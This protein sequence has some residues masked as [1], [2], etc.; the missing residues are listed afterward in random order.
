MPRKK[1]AAPA[2]PVAEDNPNRAATVLRLDPAL[3]G[4]LDAWVKRLNEGN[5]GPQWT[6][7]DLI[8]AALTRAVRERAEKGE[9]P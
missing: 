1:P 4:A 3:L 7:T 8:R 2:R 6:R 5:A 9:A